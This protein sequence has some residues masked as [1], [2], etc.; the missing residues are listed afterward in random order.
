MAVLTIN[1]AACGSAVTTTTTACQR[2][3]GLLQT[4]FEFLWQSPETG[5][6]FN[7]SEVEACESF[8]LFTSLEL[9]QN[10]SMNWFHGELESLSVGQTVWYNYDLTSCEKMYDGIYWVN[11]SLDKFSNMLNMHEL[12]SVYIVTVSG[13]EGV[14]S[15]ISE[16]CFSATTTTTT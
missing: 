11:L 16:L 7:T 3:E 2:P 5:L 8:N 10:T 9:T 12:S 14:I 1:N 4:P 15:A 13:G 6:H